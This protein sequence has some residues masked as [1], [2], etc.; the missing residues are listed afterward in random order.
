[1]GERALF[2][3]GGAFHRDIRERVAA[4]LTP[5]VLRAGRWRIAIKA[6][7]MVLWLAGSYLGLV[8]WAQA[9]WQVALLAVSMACALGG[10]AFSIGHD[11]NHGSLVRGRRLG[12]FLGLSMDLVGASS[13]VWRIK[14]NQAHHS[15]TNVE[16]ADSDIEQ[17]PLARLAPDQPLRPHHR[18]QHVYMWCMY[19]AYALKHLAIGDFRE[20]VGIKRSIGGITPISPPRGLELAMFIA[21][22]AAFWTFALVIPLLLHPW[23]VVLPV[24]AAVMWMYGFILATTFQFAHCVDEAD[25]SSVEALRDG[26]ARPWAVHQVETTVNFAPRNRVLT[27][28]MGGL[29]FQ[30]EH[31]LFPKICHVHYKRLMPI[32]REACAEHGVRYTVQP[33]WTAA[34]RSHTRWLREMGTPVPA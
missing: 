1:V 4:E 30:I 34:A 16:G 25:F 26:P 15:F 22:K 31:H 11:A 19:G 17:M 23:F 20:L 3:G 9:A 7:V 2:S 18:F 21:G 14:H 8:L 6:I 13:Y 5:S 24:F 33:T 27:W 32:I 29:N 12:R 10:V 28:Y